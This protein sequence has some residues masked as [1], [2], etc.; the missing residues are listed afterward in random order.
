MNQIQDNLNKSSIISFE[1]DDIY[2]KN[3]QLLNLEMVFPYNLKNLNYQLFLRHDHT[4]KLTNAEQKTLQFIRN[5]DQYE[6]FFKNNS[7]WDEANL[8]NVFNIIIKN[9]IN[10][11]NQSIPV[12]N[13]ISNGMY[14][15]SIRNIGD[16]FNEDNITNYSFLLDINHNSSLYEFVKKI[17]LSFTLNKLS[18]RIS[19]GFVFDFNFDEFLGFEDGVDLIYLFNLFKQNIN[20][21]LMPLNMD[22]IIEILSDTNGYIKHQHDHTSKHE[23][24]SELKKLNTVIDFKSISFEYL[25]EL[26]QNLLE[27]KFLHAHH[28]D[29]DSK[30]TS[31][32]KNDLFF[33][34]MFLLCMNLYIL[35]ELDAVLTSFDNFSVVNKTCLLE[36]LVQDKKSDFNNQDYFWNI[37]HMIHNNYLHHGAIFQTANKETVNKV[38]KQNPV[39]LSSV[40]IN[41]SLSSPNLIYSLKLLEYK[42]IVHFNEL[43][44]NDEYLTLFLMILYPQVFVLNMS[45]NA[46]FPN[47]DLIYEYV[48]Y[49]KDMDKDEYRKKIKECL[50]EN[51]YYYYS[52]VKNDSVILLENNG[53][54]PN[55]RVTL[56]NISYYYLVC[57]NF[58]QAR[59]N[60]L[61]ILQKIGNFVE[62]TNDIK[63]KNIP[64]HKLQKDLINIDFDADSISLF[65]NQKL[66]II[67]KKMDE[68]FALKQKIKDE[69]DKIRWSDE[70]FKRGIERSNF[71]VAFIVAILVGFINYFGQ[72]YSETTDSIAVG[73]GTGMNGVNY[74]G[75]WPGVDLHFPW[76]P[77]TISFASIAELSMLII[78]IYAFYRMVYFRIKIKKIDEHKIQLF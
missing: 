21:Q 53:Y 78:L 72:V 62:F 6:I 67:L 66:T 70:L 23:H 74:P 44:K 29:F 39:S 54:D 13:E 2:K 65:A 63:W 33:G 30:K 11:T 16:A 55:S 14:L 43:L 73:G 58:I 46:I 50:C 48:S 19:G 18:E 8:I 77:M 60:E 59:L 34:F 24:Y 32:L 37:V 27:E 26:W 17:K 10:S 36:N 40:K 35:Y 71:I 31:Y 22:S 3:I 20:T 56:N 64:Y 52:F 57:I 42:N 7:F 49:L 1:H 15:S 61:K 12:F 4:R 25:H 9:I 51:N 75:G 45:D 69:Q 28:H 68:D 38:I 5:N 76:V 41:Y 47:L